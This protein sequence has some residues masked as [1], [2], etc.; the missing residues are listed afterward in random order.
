M[1]LNSDIAA[2]VQIKE[3]REVI[4]SVESRLGQRSGVAEGKLP[5]KV[6]GSE[7]ASTRVISR[8]RRWPEVF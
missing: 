1:A 2:S 3:I 6:L 4:D 8:L 5:L 7:I